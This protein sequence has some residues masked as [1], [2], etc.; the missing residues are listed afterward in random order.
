VNLFKAVIKST[1]P[2]GYMHHISSFFLQSSNWL[3]CN[4][5]MWLV[6]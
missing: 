6:L 1:W 3:C 4:Y 2:A 5:M